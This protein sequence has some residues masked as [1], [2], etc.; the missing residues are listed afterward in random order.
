MIHS[1]KWLVP[2]VVLGKPVTLVSLLC[3]VDHVIAG[4]GTILRN[5][6]WFGVPGLTVFQG[7]MPALDEWLES[8]SVINRIT[9]ETNLSQVE[10]WGAEETSYRIEHHLEA[11][12][13]VTERILAVR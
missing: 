12:L 9:V 8:Q 7:P 13:R 4:G 1:R 5:A 3:E 10:W 2:P 6:S 11:I